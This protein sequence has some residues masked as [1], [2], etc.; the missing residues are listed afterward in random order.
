MSSGPL[1]GESQ[2]WSGVK[3]R[4]LREE[5]GTSQP[6][7]GEGCTKPYPWEV[8]GRADRFRCPLTLFHRVSVSEGLGLRTGCSSLAERGV[9]GPVGSEGKNPV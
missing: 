2:D 8:Q 9:P 7:N 3:V 5:M 4:L 6:P 1:K